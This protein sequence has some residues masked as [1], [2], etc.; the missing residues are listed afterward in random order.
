MKTVMKLRPIFILIV[1]LAALLNVMSRAAFAL[2]PDRSL[3]EKQDDCPWAE[4]SR[5]L[6]P[7]AQPAILGR[8]EA[9]LPELYN[10]MNAD[11]KPGT[12][13]A[14]WGRSINFDEGKKAIIVN[15]KVIYQL[16]T[17]FHQKTLKVQGKQIAHAGVEHTYGYLLSNLQTAYG[18]KRARWVH[19]I[20]DRGFGLPTGTLAPLPLQGT[21]LSN[22]TYF[23]GQIA[24]HGDPASL[25]LIKNIQGAS[26][27]VMNFDYSKLKPIRLVETVQTKTGPVEIRTD[28][29][30]FLSKVETNSHWLIYSIYDGRKGAA[31]NSQLITAFPVEASFVENALKPE[32]LGD[33]Q[34]ITTRYNAY[35]EG[36]TFTTQK[37]TRKKGL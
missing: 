22:V 28:F 12:W 3:G 23:A 27:A 6:D 1:T 34:P 35:V 25:A 19:G 29:V 21:L 26:A 18:F 10:S 31:K 17:L 13:L 11:S 5:T 36:I 14:A 4:L 32:Q 7:V 15:P 37:G 16:D 20:L 9:E 24:F 30:P 8:I 2:C 33:D